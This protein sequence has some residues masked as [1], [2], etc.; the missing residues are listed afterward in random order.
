MKKDYMTQLERAA[1]WRLP[2]EEAE[3]VI[4]DYRDIV[5]DEELRR[6]LGKPRDV[7]APLIPQKA[8]RIWLAVFTA[9]AACALLPALSAMPGM[10]HLWYLFRRLTFCVLPLDV[11][12]LS[13]SPATVLPFLGMA[14]ALVWFRWKG[15]AK[16]GR[17]SPAAPA[18]L[19]AAGVWSVAV[20]AADWFWMRDPIAFSDMWGQMPLYILGVRFG[21][22]GY[23]VSRSCHILLGALEWGG[24]AMALLSVFALVKART[25]D[26]RWAAVYILALTAVLLSADTLALLNNM[27]ISVTAP[28]WWVPT[29]RAWAVYAGVG[30]VGAGAALC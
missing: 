26:R 28:D 14:G 2:Q 4:A 27:E 5:G 10:W 17:L 15:G 9:L 29:L 24:F 16:R 1:R 30:F 11:Y 19:A 20:L 3:D 21:P 22:P 12:N 18:L 6:N 8:Y 25:R 23:T 7:I 13:I